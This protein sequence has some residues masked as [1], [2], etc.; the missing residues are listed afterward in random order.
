MQPSLYAAFHTKSSM[1]SY[2]SKSLCP[3]VVD[4]HEISCVLV[5]PSSTFDV[6]QLA[7][8]GECGIEASVCRG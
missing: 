7:E 1:L 8:R 5:L 6:Y 3:D 2:E 4:W